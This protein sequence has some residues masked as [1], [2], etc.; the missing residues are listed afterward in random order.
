[1]PGNSVTDNSQRIWVF[2]ESKLDQAIETYRSAAIK[3]YPHQEE[4]IN[5]T[6]LAFKDFLDS[7]EAAKLRMNIKNNEK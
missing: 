2:D 4:K 3:A 1:M 5:L 7:D 6:V